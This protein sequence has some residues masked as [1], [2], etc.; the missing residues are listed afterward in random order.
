MENM[1][2]AYYLRGVLGNQRHVNREQSSIVAYV[3]EIGKATRRHDGKSK[4]R[5]GFTKDLLKFP[6]L[7]GS[8]R[9]LAGLETTSL[10]EEAKR[11]CY[12]LES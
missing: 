7:M 11:R 12:L 6:G 8:L 1:R 9:R 5:S 3:N 10:E 2:R 4:E